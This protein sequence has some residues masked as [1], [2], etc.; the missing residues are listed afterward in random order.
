MPVAWL[1]HLALVPPGLGGS[2]FLRPFCHSF[3]IKLLADFSVGLDQDFL[4]LPVRILREYPNRI[5]SLII[6]SRSFLFV[7]FAINTFVYVYIYIC[8]DRILTFGIRSIRS[9]TRV[10]IG[11]L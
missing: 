2:G 9:P 10:G 4:L 6:R 7:L 1:L 11:Y 5:A 3:V 8:S